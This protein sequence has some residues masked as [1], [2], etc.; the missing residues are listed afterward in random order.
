M[1]L[2]T[3]RLRRKFSSGTVEYFAILPRALAIDDDFTNLPWLKSR[4]FLARSN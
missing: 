2:Y 1:A 4:T 3:L